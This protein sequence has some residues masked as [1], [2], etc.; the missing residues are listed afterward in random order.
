MMSSHLAL[1]ETTKWYQNSH[2]MEFYVRDILAPYC[3]YLRNAM[4]NPV[5][6]VF[7]IMDNCPSHNKRELLTLYTQYNIRVIW[8]PAHSSHFL[9]PLDLGLCGEWKGRYQRFSRK[10]TSPRWQ[11]KVF[12]VDRAWNGSTYVL[13]VWNSWEA[14]AIRP[15]TSAILRWYV[16]RTK[17]EEKITQLQ[18][19]GTHRDDSMA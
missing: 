18:M 7:L 14:A 13:N 4:H 5:L 3:E 19:A 9:Q 8:L 2:S 10:L 11:G 17:L 16:D 1:Y 12:R 6:P 15:S